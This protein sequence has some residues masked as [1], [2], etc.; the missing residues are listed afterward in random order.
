MGIDW[1]QCP[2]VESLPGRCSGV[3]VVKGT[4]IPVQAIIDNFEG[5]WTFAPAPHTLGKRI[6]MV[7]CCR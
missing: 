3:P 4:R 6:R 7:K 1:S 5:G 2:D